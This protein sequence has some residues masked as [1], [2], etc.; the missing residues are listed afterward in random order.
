MKNMVYMLDLLPISRSGGIA[1]LSA[2]LLTMVACGKNSAPPTLD[3]QQ[4][5]AIAEARAVCSSANII[6]CCIDAARRD[7]LGCYGYSRPTTPEIDKLAEQSVLFKNAVSDASYTLAA[8]ASLWTGQAPDS[9]GLTVVG[10]RLPLDITTLPEACKEA[11]L[12]TAVVSSSNMIH[13]KFGFGDGA[14]IFHS[15]SSD[16]KQPL[17]LQKAWQEE[18]AKIS[19]KRFFLYLHIF[20]PHHPYELSGQFQGEFAT[21]HLTSLAQRPEDTINRHVPESTLDILPQLDQGE[22]VVSE[23]QRQHIIAMYDERLKYAD[24]IV[25]RFLADLKQY[26]VLDNSIFILFADHGESFGEHG[27]WLHAN[28]VYNAQTHIPL[29]I[30]FPVGVEKVPP[31]VNKLVQLSDIAPTL[32][33]LAGLSFPNGQLQGSDF[34]SEIFGTSAHSGTAFSRCLKEPRLFWGIELPEG[35]GI[36]DENGNLIELYD[37]QRD[38]EEKHNLLKKDLK[39]KTQM[40]SLYSTWTQRQ[41]HISPAAQEAIKKAAAEGRNKLDKEA[42]RELKALGYL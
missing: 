4:V 13:K 19:R 18:L 22:L 33:F 35:K 31:A 7:H 36:F 11:G 25:G 3:P 38:P 41:K 12:H 23:A 6:I 9:N 1:L 2:L 24:W 32:C 30:R 14:D 8:I 15:A 42:Y 34:T 21:S 20:P 40:V 29:L 10:M 28:T 27:R 37:L 39:L 26:Q 17:P 5:E 16:P